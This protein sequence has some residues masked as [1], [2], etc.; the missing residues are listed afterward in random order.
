MAKLI[1]EDG[2]FKE[3]IDFVYD[4]VTPSRTSFVKGAIGDLLFRLFLLTSMIALMFLS[5]KRVTGMTI[6]LMLAVILIAVLTIKKLLY[7]I[8]LLMSDGLRGMIFTFVVFII[9]LL[10]LAFY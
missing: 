5:I 8:N 3:T 10:V 9:F 6:I 7:T 2:Y 4:A 1:S